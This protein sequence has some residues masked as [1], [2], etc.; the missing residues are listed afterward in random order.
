MKEACLWGVGC[1]FGRTNSEVAERKRGGGRPRQETSPE[2][3]FLMREHAVSTRRVPV[4]R[5][6]VA[7]WMLTARNLLGANPLLGNGWFILLILFAWA[8]FVFY[9]NLGTVLIGDEALYAAIAQR[10]VRTKEWLPLIYQGQP[11]FNKPPLH[12]WVM[13]LSLRLW[14]PGEFAI[15]FPS[16]TFGIGMT[17]LTL[18]LRQGLVPSSAR[19]DRGPH[20]DHHPVHG[21]A[22]P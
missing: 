5:K 14:G 10:V 4:G 3:S 21:L 13:A 17:V 12:F 20:H 11:Y 19:G 18:L 8:G 6:V 22:R 1:G 9:S 7:D 16:A 2:H 15:R